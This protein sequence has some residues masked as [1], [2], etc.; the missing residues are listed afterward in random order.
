MSL[1]ILKPY[2]SRTGTPILMKLCMWLRHVPRKII[3]PLAPLII[4]PFAARASRVPQYKMSLCPNMSV[5]MSQC[6]SVCPM[7]VRMSQFPNTL[8]LSP[9][10]CKVDPRS[11]SLWRVFE[12]ELFRL[13]T[14]YLGTKLNF[15]YHRES[16]NDLKPVL[17]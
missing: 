8:S 2:I 7:S 5:R 6:P 12:K 4:A 16:T 13:Q 11:G 10:M 15:C 14:L 1:C 9:N 3:G 17:N